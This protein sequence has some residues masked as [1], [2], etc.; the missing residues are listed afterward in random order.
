MM[1]QLYSKFFSGYKTIKVIDKK[2]GSHHFLGEVQNTWRERLPVNAECGD[3][4]STKFIHKEISAESVVESIS[5]KI[6]ATL[7]DKKLASLSAEINAAFS[8][9]RSF[10]TETGLEIPIEVKAPPCGTAAKVIYELVKIIDVEVKN[11]SI[12]R[13][14]NPKKIKEEIPLSIFTT[15]LFSEPFSEEC[16]CDP[17]DNKGFFDKLKD[18]FFNNLMGFTVTEGNN[19]A[20][21]VFCVYEHKDKIFGLFDDLKQVLPINVASLRSGKEVSFSMNYQLSPTSIKEGCYWLEDGAERELKCT[22]L[23]LDEIPITLKFPEFLE[24]EEKEVKHPLL[25][26][27]EKLGESVLEA[28]LVLPINVLSQLAGQTNLLALNA[29]IEAARAGERGRSFAVIANDVRELAVKTQSAVEKLRNLSAWS[30]SAKTSLE[31][32]I[33]FSKLAE[34]SVIQAG[35]SLN[36]ELSQVI[37]KLNSNAELLK[38][39]NQDLIKISGSQGL[40]EEYMKNSSPDIAKLNRQAS[41]TENL[42]E[43]LNSDSKYLSVIMPMIGTDKL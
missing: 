30:R 14:S 2:V 38:R 18:G 25:K 28:E 37:D 17:H 26:F 8:I 15:K 34:I 27:I 20:S 41:E 5:T 16:N 35:K 32:Q 31:T 13:R 12:F 6:S 33:E 23:T 4:T 11:T 22:I 9:T 7:G 3:S 43:K 19:S 40:I 24:K 29:A 1:A 21:F 39:S 42:M 10:G 36:E